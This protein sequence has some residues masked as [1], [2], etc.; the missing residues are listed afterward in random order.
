MRVSVSQ[1][2]TVGGSPVL[3]V[4]LE[5]AGTFSIGYH[6]A[7]LKVGGTTHPTVQFALLLD[8]LCAIPTFLAG[9]AYASTAAATGAGVPLAAA[10][11]GVGAVAAFVAGWLPAF[12][13]PKR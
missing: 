2:A 12:H 13:E 6:W 3:G 9:L 1:M 5:L 8:Y 11:C 10:A 7:Q 4:L